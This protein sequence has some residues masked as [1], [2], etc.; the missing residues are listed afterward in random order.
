MTKNF[1]LTLEVLD[2]VGR[3]FH[4]FMDI[5]MATN[6][7]SSMRLTIRVIFKFTGTIYTYCINPDET[8]NCY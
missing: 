7:I 8:I 6:Y 4:D 1:L 2:F 3:N 5:L